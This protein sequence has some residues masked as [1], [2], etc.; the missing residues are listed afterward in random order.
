MGL[1]QVAFKE[2]NALSILGENNELHVFGPTLEY[3][4]IHLLPIVK[5][6]YVIF[7]KWHD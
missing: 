3:H 5:M 1:F 2:S 7:I 6:I 4:L